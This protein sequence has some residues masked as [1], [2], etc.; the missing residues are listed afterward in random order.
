MN[1][2][3]IESVQKLQSH[4]SITLKTCLTVG[5]HENEHTKIL[6]DISK[7]TVPFLTMYTGNFSFYDVLR[8]L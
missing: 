2:N 3:L 7:Y 1:C 5:F 8:K 4:P 6:E